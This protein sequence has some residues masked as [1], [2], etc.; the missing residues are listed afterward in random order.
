MC[1]GPHPFIP[2]PNTAQALV[3]FTQEQS[4]METCLWFKK[5]T[6]WE[7]SDLVTLAG[8]LDTWWDTRL[9]PLI[10]QNVSFVEV[11]CTDWS[12]ENGAQAISRTSFGTNGTHQGT[13]LPSNVSWALKLATG[14]RGRSF[15]GRVFLYGLTASDIDGSAVLDSYAVPA[16]AAWNNLLGT[17]IT[18]PGANLAVVSF[19]A[20][21]SWRTTAVVTNV[22]NIVAVDQTVDSMRKRLPGRGR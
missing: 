5:T 12:T 20:A 8:D 19:C 9:K 15:R 22:T 17:D 4:H 3:R 11:V 7:E 14:L 13:A 6:A 18:V 16:V 10:A 2:A 21:G 1:T